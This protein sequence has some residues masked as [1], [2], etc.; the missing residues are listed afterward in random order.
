MLIMD[1]ST[2]HCAN[3]DRNAPYRRTSVHFDP[4]YAERLCSV[5]G[6]DLLRHFRNGS[7]RLLRLTAAEQVAL[8]EKLDT[9][10][11][12]YMHANALAFNRLHAQFLE[13]LLMIHEFCTKSQYQ[14]ENVSRPAKEKIV[15]EILRFIELHYR[16]EFRLDAL[17][18]KLHLSKNHLS[19]IFR[20][21]TGIRIT[22]YLNQR[23]IN[24][25]MV[26]L[27]SRNKRRTIHTIGLEI[28]FKTHGHFTRVFKQ[29]TGYSPQQF[30][31]LY[32]LNPYTTY[33]Q[34]GKS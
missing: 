12:L 22:E 31:Q 25:A 8:Q 15:W 17:E 14:S 30:R 28:G 3:P 32:T 6:I 11:Q 5:F 23:R 19:R 29:H 18:K 26:M 34:S 9:I 20:E 33:H 13:L 10:N 1:G 7:H 21:V 24:Q 4:D 2:P 27:Q 16:E